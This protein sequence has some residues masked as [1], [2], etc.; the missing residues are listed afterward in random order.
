MILKICRVRDPQNIVEVCGLRPAYI[1]FDFRA[2]EP[3]YI[4]GIDP[5]L[6]SV[7]PS[8]PAGPL[9]VG[10]FGG[11]EGALH[12]SYIAGR[13]SLGAVQVEGTVSP[14][15]LEQLTAEGLEVIKVLDNLEDAGRYE[16]VC[17]RFLVRRAE[18]LEG[19]RNSGGTTP[20]IVDFSLADHPHS[21]GAVVDIFNHFEQSIAY[22]DCKKIEN[23][24]KNR[25]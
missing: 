15:T 17:N 20:M 12:I 10:V 5:G 4:G 13:F 8:G 11:Q 9:K 16:G 22:K 18:V 19:Y 25:V 7:I 21:A 3:G 1:G 24:R 23:W 2:G 6:L 14:Q